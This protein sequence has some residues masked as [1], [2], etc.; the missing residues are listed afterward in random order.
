MTAMEKIHGRHAKEYEKVL[1]T[2][3]NPLREGHH[4]DQTLGGVAGLFDNIRSNTQG[5]ATS[6]GET[7]KTLKS[8]ILP[9]FERL[10]TEIK[11]K[12][13]ELSKGAGKGAKAVEKARNV[14]Q[15]ELSDRH[16][17][18]HG[19]LHFAA[20]HVVICNHRLCV[21]QHDRQESQT[22]TRRRSGPC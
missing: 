5:M 4:F 16:N 19:L 1:K 22:C 9:V 12:T 18:F 13:K 7:A 20:R 2:I 17:S 10:H 3:S 11:N 6:H 15:K 14:S 21:Y 8:S